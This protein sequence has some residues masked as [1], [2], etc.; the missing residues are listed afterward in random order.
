MH[1]IITPLSLSFALHLPPVLSLFLWAAGWVK[2]SVSWFPHQIMCEPCVR[3]CTLRQSV[4]MST[5]GGLR[6]E[7]HT[8]THAHTQTCIL[9]APHTQTHMNT[10]TLVHANTHTWWF[11]GQCEVG[12]RSPDTNMKKS[13][14]KE[15]NI[16]LDKENN[17]LPLKCTCSVLMRKMQIKKEYKLSFMVDKVKHFYL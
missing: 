10:H 11:A 6:I 13:F 5:Y 2:I 3:A 14:S 12:H 7:T 4:L 15:G 9:I 17:F 1:I 8:H 16:I